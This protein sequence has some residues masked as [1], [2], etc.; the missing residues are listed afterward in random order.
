MKEPTEQDFLDHM[1]LIKYVAIKYAKNLFDADDVVQQTYILYKQK[2]DSN[3]LY[4][5][6]PEKF[7]TTLGTLVFQAYYSLKYNKHRKEKKSESDR[8]VFTDELSDQTE[9]TTQEILDSIFL[10]EEITY[11]LSEKFSQEQIYL[12]DLYIQGYDYNQIEQKTQVK[13]LNAA[14]LV[15]NMKSYLKQ[16]QSKLYP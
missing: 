12:F 3:Q 16:F 6:S 15:S 1:Q 5:I 2:I 8:V 14:K 7:R 4:I 11:F 9:S 13:Y 10:K